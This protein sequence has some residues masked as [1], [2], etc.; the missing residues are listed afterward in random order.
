MTTQ[1]EQEEDEQGRKQVQVHVTYL[2]TNEEVRFRVGTEETL[3]AVWDRAYSELGE[4]R[5]DGD[6]LQCADGTSLMGDLDRTMAEVRD[7][8][9]C[10]GRRLEIRSETGG[11]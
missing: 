9:L 1:V 3:A 2:N 8:Q 5:R 6:Q 7:Q 4:A 11:A 10:P